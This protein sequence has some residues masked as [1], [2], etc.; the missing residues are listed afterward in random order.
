M[1]RLRHPAARAA[2]RARARD[3]ARRRTLLRRP[4]RAK[5]PAPGV[6]RHPTLGGSES[7]LKYLAMHLKAH[8]PNQQPEKRAARLAK[9]RE[10]TDS[11]SLGHQLIEM[12]VQ[13]AEQQAEVREVEVRMELSFAARDD[14]EVRVAIDYAS[15]AQRAS[16]LAEGWDRA[17]DGPTGHSL[18]RG[19]A[20][21]G[22]PR[23]GRAVE[24]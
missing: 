5:Q 17:R 4:A 9:L 12:L 19:G 2:H 7:A 20:R 11:C 14:G 24:R 23:P 21:G 6:R 18:L 16:R 1:S 15:E 3:A 13:P 22:A 8:N 10:Y